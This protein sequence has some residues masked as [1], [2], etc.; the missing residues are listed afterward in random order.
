MCIVGYK[1]KN[2]ELHNAWL[3]DCAIRLLCVFALDRFADFVSDQVVCPVRE[4]C[5][6]TLGVVLQYMTPEA[7]GK[8]HEN[9]LKLINQQDPAFAG[10]SIWEVR[11]AGLLG[12]KYTVAVRKDLVEMLV[13]GTT[14][15][16]ILGLRDHDDDVRAVSAATLLPI[17]SEFVRLSSK[18]R[19]RDVIL[20]LWDCLIDLMDD[21]TA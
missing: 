2:K 13:E 9:L 19:I 5:S 11:H 12:L 17:T 10:K 6:Q 3:E 16:I 14:G 18:E 1:E 15:A 20:T 21:L 8:V 7:V 4:T